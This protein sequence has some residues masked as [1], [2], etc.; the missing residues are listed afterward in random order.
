LTFAELLN[1]TNLPPERIDKESIMSNEPPALCQ[2]DPRYYALD[3]HGAGTVAIAKTERVGADLL[4]FGLPSMTAL[5]LSQS[6]KA[7]AQRKS[8]PIS[9]LFQST[10]QG[11]Q[12]FDHKPLFDTFEFLIMEVVFAFSA[13]ESFANQ[14]LPLD[15]EL[16]LPRQ[17]KRCTEL[18]SK[19]QAERLSLDV[20]LD[21]A[22]PQVFGVQSP[23]GTKIWQDYVELKNLR[24]RIIHLKSADTKSSG[25]ETDSVWGDLLRAR[26]SDHSKRTATIIGYYLAKAD[27]PRWY[28]R[29]P[30]RE[31]DSK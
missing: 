15:F 22:L 23:K 28:R 9:D 3:A 2:E 16:R 5:F 30:Y 21:I 4:H 1:Q 27:K 6:E 19:A 10:D 14:A 7:H 17:D 8:I 29:F 20:K 11:L 13:L 25:P 18:F 31:D 24:D 12:A 26:E